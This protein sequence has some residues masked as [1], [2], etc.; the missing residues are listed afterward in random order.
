MNSN[1]AIIRS[2]DDT[3]EPSNTNTPFMQELTFTPPTEIEQDYCIKSDTTPVKASPAQ[4]VHFHPVVAVIR[5]AIRSTSHV[6]DLTVADA[7]LVSVLTIFNHDK[8][9]DITFLETAIRAIAQ[10]ARRGVTVVVESSVSRG[11]DKR[12]PRPPYRH[13]KRESRHVSSGISYQPLST[14]LASIRCLRVDAGGEFP[15]FQSIP[16]IISVFDHL[17]PISSLERIVCVAY[18]SEMADTYASLGIDATEVISWRPFEIAGRLMRVLECKRCTTKT[19][20]R[21]PASNTSHF[22]GVG[23]K[24]GQ[25]LLYNSPGCH[26]DVEF[27]DPLVDQEALSYVLRLDTFVNWNKNHLAELAGILVIVDQ[28]GHDLDLLDSLDK[29]VVHDYSHTLASS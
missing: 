3:M 1:P 22:V 28:V 27:A 13:E 2:W 25:N 15:A 10:H 26:L 20:R 23:F 14:S 7:F 9:I 16:K 12:A 8:T 18:T 24:W 17:V 21:V 19:R 11:H 5:L 29:V 4:E 6:S